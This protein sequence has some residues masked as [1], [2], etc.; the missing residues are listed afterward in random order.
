MERIKSK[1][2]VM[3]SEQRLAFSILSTLWLTGQIHLPSVFVSI[4]QNSAMS[5]CLRVVYAAF[6][7]QQQN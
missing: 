5:I 2:W 4:L 1:L 3:F 6:L 7:W